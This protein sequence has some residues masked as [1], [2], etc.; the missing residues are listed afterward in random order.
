MFMGGIHT[1]HCIQVVGRVVVGHM[2]KDEG[3]NEEI[4]R[5]SASQ[6]NKAPQDLVDI[7]PKGC[8]YI[9]Q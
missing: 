9:V 3:A 1:Y 2:G 5:D 7:T 8:C 4:C 6:C